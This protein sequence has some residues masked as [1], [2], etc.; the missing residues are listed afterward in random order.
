M[1]F[2]NVCDIDWV[3]AADYYAC[4]HVGSDTHILRRSLSELERDLG[5][6]DFVRIHR[7]IIVNLDRI[8]GLVLQDGGEY[9]V[10]IEIQ[11]SIAVEPTLSQA[12]S[13]LYGG[14]GIT[15][16]G[17]ILRNAE[18]GCGADLGLWPEVRRFET[19][20]VRDTVRRY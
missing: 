12:T 14:A 18:I 11:S 13:G 20:K 6:G 1:Q 2:L 8:R 9:E 4:L 7:S 16:S 3:E 17:T 5:D 15:R 19:F 10:E